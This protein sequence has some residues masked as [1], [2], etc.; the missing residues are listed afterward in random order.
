MLAIV[1]ITAPIFLLIAIGYAA[2]RSRLLPYEAIPGLGRFVLYFALPSL[3]VNTLS[4]MDIEEVI[5]PGFILAY[6]LGSLLMIG[7]GLLLTLKIL[8]NEP[9]LASLK[10][11]GMT[12]S[13]TPYFGFAVLLQ[14]LDNVA[15]Q[16]LAMAMLVETLLIIPLSMTL[17]EFHASRSIG[18]SLGRVLIKLPQRILRNPLVISITSGIVIS[19][20]DISLPQAVST[21]LEMLG[22]SSAAIALF[23]IGASLVGNVINLSPRSPL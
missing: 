23:V 15:G 21:T 16:A 11:M 17:L 3:I 18:M 7:L 14:V 20:L 8:K 4:S 5:E 10:A 9:V 2:V 1:S 13:N 12:V 22:R 6:A 19:S